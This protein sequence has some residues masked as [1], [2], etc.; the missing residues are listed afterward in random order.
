MTA[1]QGAAT[2]AGYLRQRRPFF[3]ARIGDG[4]IEC[5]QGRKGQTCDGERYSLELAA[6]LRKAIDA[7]KSGGAIFGD[8]RTAVAGSEPKYVPEWEKLIE[9]AGRELLNYESLLLMRQSEPLVDFYR[10]ARNDSR[11]KMYIGRDAVEAV[12]TLDCRR[13]I[14]TSMK[15]DLEGTRLLIEDIRWESPSVI[16]FG[17]GM[18]GLIAVVKYWQENPGVTCIHLGSA[19]DP[20]FRQ[21]RQRQ[22]PMKVARAMFKELL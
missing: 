19:L 1:D 21:S 14:V 16:L 7:L 20:L 2:L 9:P 5:L 10:A 17:A 3:F 18:A 13:G 22:L 4:A 12:A 8:W 6:E 15:L 11:K